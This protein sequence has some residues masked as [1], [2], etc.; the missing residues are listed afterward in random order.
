MLDQGFEPEIRLIMESKGMPD[1]EA[2]Q[3]LMFSATFAAEIQTL[4]R[5]FLKPDHVFKAVGIL[6]GA[7]QDIKQEI[8]QVDRSDKKDKLVEMLQADL[9]DA[10]DANGAWVK[11]TL[12][13]VETKRT[14]DFVSTVLSQYELPSTSIHGDREQ[15]Q[16]EEALRDFKSGKRPFLVATSVAAR[17]LDI[18]GV[19]HVINYDLP[20]DADDYVHRVGR[21]GRVGN[22]GRATAFYDRDKD[23]TIAADLVKILADAQQTV[24]DWLAAETGMGGGGGGAGFGAA[25]NDDENW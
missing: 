13:F 23:T 18:V 9:N 4:A 21:T 14:A 17:G 11:K 5:E 12:V 1:K 22:I 8:L 19:D 20:G 25:A 24:P 7:N 16:R 6:G 3:T 15:R 10:K 2:R